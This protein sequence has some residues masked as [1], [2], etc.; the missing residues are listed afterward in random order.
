[1]TVDRQHFRT[2]LAE[3]VA[4]PTVSMDPDRAADMARGAEW[5]AET[6]RSLGGEATI[7]R[8][9]GWPTVHGRFRAEGATRSIAIYNHLDVQP[10]NEPEWRTEPFVLTEVGDTWYGR[11]ATDDKGPAL[12]A[13]FAAARSRQAGVPL[14]IHFIWEFEEEI[15]SPNFDEALA[16][17]PGPFDSVLVSDTIWIS[18]DVPASPLGLRGMQT[19][20]LNLRTASHDTHSGLVGG[21]A[22][23]PLLE[24]AELIAAMVDAESGRVKIPG[25]YDGVRQ[26]DEATLEGFVR[27]GFDVE[28]FRKAHGLTSLRDLDPRIVTQKLWTLPTMELHG[29]A[30]GYQGPGVKSAVPPWGEAKMSMRLVPDMT[31]EGAL[32]RVR[33]FVSVHHP[34]VEVVA[35]PGLEPYM[36]PSDAA[37]I[38]HLAAALK[39]AFGKEPAFV[40]EG[41]SI[42]AVVRMA[43]HWQ[44]PVLFMGLSLPEHGYHAPNE[45]FDWPMAQGGI[46]AFEHYFRSQG[47]C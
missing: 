30:G 3:G 43:R 34:E 39:H 16:R 32:A 27:A 29:L 2:L 4:I 40:R 35:G 1:M 45:N 33:D 11:G 24:L 38:P 18:R 25:F 7:L 31:A 20:T 17:I 10:A 36:C 46:A 6:I 41:G 28:R 44:C 9:S 8:T 5:A 47:T 14:D 15:G 19:F 22:R 37:Q 12:A 42:G 23:N 21:A 13:L 26:T